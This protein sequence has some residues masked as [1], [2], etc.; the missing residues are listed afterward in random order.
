MVLNVNYE[1]EV[2]KILRTLDDSKK[3]AVLDMAKSLSK[4]PPSISGKELL[5]RTKNIR[6]SDEDAQEMMQAI[7]EAFNS[8]EDIQV[9]LDE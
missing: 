9:N 3:Q 2:L 1:E 7:D 8:I 6:L 4:H 5:D